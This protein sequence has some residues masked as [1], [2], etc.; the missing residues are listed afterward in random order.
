MPELPEVETVR[1]M[2][3]PQLIGQTI[4]S[5]SV[6]NPQIIAYPDATAFAALLTGQTVRRMSRRG[7]FLTVHFE[8]GDRLVIHLRMTGQLLVTPSDYPVEKH[9]HLQA[10]LSVG[11][12]IRYIDVR[13][14]GRFWYLKADEPDSIT[15]QDKLGLEPLD[16]ALTKDYLKARLGG[17]KKSIKEMLHDQSVVAGI[18]NIYSDEILFEAGLYP[19]E[20]CFDLTAGDWDSLSAKIKEVIAWGIKANE[21]TP[22]EYLAGAGKEYRNM[23]DLRVYGREGQPC[24]RCGAAIERIVI[25]GRSS[26]YCPVCQRKKS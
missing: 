24:S 10:A 11:C 17:R 6:S 2:I 14:F 3:E 19:E 15:G 16:D 13:R 5:V 4:L 22:E 8:S 20:K 7:K 1:R 21:T 23:P 26:C 25:G 18:G 12:Q 9:T